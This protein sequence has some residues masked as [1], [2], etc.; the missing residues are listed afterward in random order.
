MSIADSLPPADPSARPVLELLDGFRASKA[1][2]VAV[3]FGLFDRLHQGAAGL[4]E[5][6]SERGLASHALERLLGFLV[7]RGLLVLNEAGE[8]SNTESADRFLRTD[9]TETLAGYILYSER[10]LY[11]MW[12]RLDDAIREGTNR[13]EQEFGAKDGIFD[14][15]F[16]TNEDKETFLRGMHG[17]GMLSS[18]RVA[19]SFDLKPYRRLV[20]VGGATGHLAIE[21]CRQYPE[22]D[23]V[24]F[25]LP[26][27]VPVAA[28]QVAEAGLSERV[29]TASGD[30]FSDP[31]PPA[32]LYAL[33]RILHDWGDEKVRLL[34]AKIAAAL[35][36]GGG[37]LI[38]EQIVNERKDGPPTA[39]LQSL[40]MLIVCEG[41][42]RTSAEY[43]AL[44][45]EAGFSSF[46]ARR[47][48]PPVDVILARK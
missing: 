8:Y 39:L 5:L 41:R 1:L 7:S 33:G 30:F 27:V 48:G 31:L 12:G 13:W 2:F 20:D 36:A 25:D 44:V 32:D 28:R 46:E 40:N 42:E 29:G 9:S 34:L 24:V 17:L 37:L 6:A 38:C 21:A 16:S 47:I 35:P 45:R 10:V 19:A 23:A 11:R 4:D 15:F 22:L 14:H 43:E 18:P 3:S 26:S